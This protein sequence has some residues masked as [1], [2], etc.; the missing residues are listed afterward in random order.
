MQVFIFFRALLDRSI[1]AFCAF[2]GSQ[3]PQFFQQYTQKLMGHVEELDR[4][5]QQLAQIAHLSGKNL[6]QYIEKFALSSDTDFKSQGEFLNNLVIRWDELSRHL[7]ELNQSTVWSRPFIFFKQMNQELVHSTWSSFQP[8]LSFNLE[9]LG[10][11]FFGM[12]IGL[13]FC[14]IFFS[15]LKFIYSIVLGL[16]RR[17]KSAT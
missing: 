12:L 10:Y 17:A 14:Q 9:S 5:M 6:D 2:C 8:G 7:S 1:V 13:V 4:L 16:Y 11:V 3:I 15:F